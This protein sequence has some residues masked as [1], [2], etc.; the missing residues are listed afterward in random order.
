MVNHA[1]NNEMANIIV[2]PYLAGTV[3]HATT[4][5]AAKIIDNIFLWH[6]QWTQSTIKMK[7]D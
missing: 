7:I 1:M 3:N 6:V 4:D 2:T 5:T